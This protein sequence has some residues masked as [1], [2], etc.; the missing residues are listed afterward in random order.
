ML[1]YSERLDQALRKSG[2]SK[3]KL[4]KTL[5]L[6]YQA[7]SKA[8]SGETKS[9]SAANNNQAALVLGVHVGW[10]ATG[11]TPPSDNGKELLPLTAEESRL[12]QLFRALP[13]PAQEEAHDRVKA[14]AKRQAFD[15]NAILD[16]SGEA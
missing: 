16:A 13:Q 12:I 8:L 2:I 1:T 10:L 6:S 15:L 9:L 4:A 5:G 3:S 7:I 14:L 11:E